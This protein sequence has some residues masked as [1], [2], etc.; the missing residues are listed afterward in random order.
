MTNVISKVYVKRKHLKG[1]CAHRISDR[2]NEEYQK[3]IGEDLRYCNRLGKTLELSLQL[4][5]TGPLSV[6]RNNVEE[7]Y[8][9]LNGQLGST[10]DLNDT[11]VESVLNQLFEGE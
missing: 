7:M 2:L 8:E 1:V 10:Y 6:T 5:R 3:L 9:E 11:L 4:D